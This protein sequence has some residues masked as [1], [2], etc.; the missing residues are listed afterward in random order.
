MRQR[1]ISLFNY[2][3]ADIIKDKYIT[4]YAVP[5]DHNLNWDEDEELLISY[6]PE[7]QD[8]LVLVLATN[9]NLD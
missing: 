9:L 1:D 4:P 2:R 6:E 3:L 8:D 7:S 5:Y